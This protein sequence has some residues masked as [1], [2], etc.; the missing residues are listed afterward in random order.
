MD[1]ASESEVPWKRITVEAAAIVGSILLAFAIDAWWEDRNEAELER[2]L[3]TALLVE[4]EQ[5]GELLRQARTVYEQRYMEALRILEYL[6]KGAIRRDHAELEESYR[7]L[8]ITETLHLELGA[9]D[10]LLGSGELS[11]IRG[12][13]LRNRLAAWPSYVKEWSE[14]Q[15]MVFKFVRNEL[16]PYLSDSVRIRNIANSFAPFPDG[17]SPPLVPAGS[18]DAASVV[19]VSTSVEFENL[20]YQ[21]AQGLWY[22]MRDGETL[23]AQATAIAELIRENLEK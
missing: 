2:R 20:V 17:E 9:H 14:E 22:A 13:E 10:G 6:E 4:F 23:L 8:L 3:L 21:R 11:L 18:Y 15:D 7:G 19:D 12:E 5:N 1:M 16:V